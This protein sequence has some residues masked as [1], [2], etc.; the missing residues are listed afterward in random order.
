[1]SKSR[2]LFKLRT[3]SAICGLTACPHTSDAKRFET[4]FMFYIPILGMHS[5]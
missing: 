1:M 5:Q 2:L 4:L 3:L